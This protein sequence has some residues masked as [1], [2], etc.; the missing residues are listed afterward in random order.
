MTT[1]TRKTPR[2]ASTETTA[3]E[4]T[5]VPTR[6]RDAKS[7]PSTGTRHEEKTAMSA[8]SH[9]THATHPNETAAMPTSIQDA[10]VPPPVHPS[11]AAVPAPA[12]APAAVPAIVSSV[13]PPPTG[14]KIPVPPAGFTPATPGEF[15]SVVPRKS[16]LAALPQALI[17]L[18][19]F[20]DFDALFAGIG[21]TQAEV[22]QCLLVGS[23]WSTMRL[24][25]SQWDDYSVLQEGYAW[26][27]IRAALLRL[28]QAFLLAAQANPKLVTTYPGL[29]GLLGAKSA[30]AQ[31]GASTRRLNKAAKAKGEPETHG[32][33]G[34]KRLR[35]AEKAAL[36]IPAPAT[37]VAVLTPAAPAT[38]VTPAAPPVA[39][40]PPGPAVTNGASN[41]AAH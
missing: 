26:R 11:I 20:A 13:D 33:V 6:T 24:A 15:R 30:I 4:K 29:A 41:G 12:P 40:S 10:P 25:S 28:E 9:P 19:K 8:K 21:L 23:L 37:P 38:P 27:A 32:V 1:T 39:P 5:A 31:R 16:E 36:A 14:A 34:K 18:A 22:T 7:H 3:E 17:D 2:H 35:R